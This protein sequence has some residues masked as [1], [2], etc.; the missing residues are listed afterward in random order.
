LLC[1]PFS[2]L[3]SGGAIV[4]AGDSASV[5]WTMAMVARASSAESCVLSSCYVPP[6]EK[7]KT[8]DRRSAFQFT[9]FPPLPKYFSKI[10]VRWTDKQVFMWIQYR[11]E[12]VQ[13]HNRKVLRS[14]KLFQECFGPAT[15][16]VWFMQARRIN[17]AIPSWLLN[18]INWISQRKKRH[19]S[20]RP[21]HNL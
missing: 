16:C 8:P 19:S 21:K 11:S 4:A 2:T 5:W 6:K 10:T 13:Y 18:T 7:H 15:E 17:D 1:S 9:A 12:D 3:T 14:E 20:K